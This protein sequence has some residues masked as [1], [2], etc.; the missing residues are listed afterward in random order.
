MSNLVKEV[1]SFD[2]KVFKISGPLGKNMTL[3]SGEGKI[4]IGQVLSIDETTGKLIKYVAKGLEEEDPGTATEA[5]TIA[6]SDADASSGDT[7]VLVALPN[8]V[9]NKAEIKGADLG[10]D[11]KCIKELWKSGIILEEVE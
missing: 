3:K 1:T 4:Q 5:L 2:T 8:T 11:Y 10:T 7:V 9:F 6:L